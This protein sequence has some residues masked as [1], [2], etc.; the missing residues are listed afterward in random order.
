MTTNEAAE[1]LLQTASEGEAIV[2]QRTAL[3]PLVTYH[4]DDFLAAAKAEGAREAVERIRAAYKVESLWE[5]ED[6]DTPLGSPVSETKLLAIL[7]E[8]AVR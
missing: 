1:R 4:P 3:G 5:W 2:V 6:S 7:D 8:E